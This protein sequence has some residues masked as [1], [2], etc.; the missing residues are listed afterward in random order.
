MASLT[1]KLPCIPRLIYNLAIAENRFE[2]TARIVAQLQKNRFDPIVD[3]AA[4][5]IESD[6]GVEEIALDSVHNDCDV[7]RSPDSHIQLTFKG[8]ASRFS[9]ALVGLVEDRFPDRGK[10]RAVP[11][12]EAPEGLG[13]RP[14]KSPMREAKG[15]KDRT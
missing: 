2:E 15:K 13:T 1:A 4:S 5:P 8:P 9:A 12:E 11:L 14:C 3:I 10:Q 7:A 6:L